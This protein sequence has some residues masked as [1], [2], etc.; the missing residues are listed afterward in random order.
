[1]IPLVANANAALSLAPEPMEFWA[2]L[3]NSDFQRHREGVLY[4][5]DEV[6][7]IQHDKFLEEDYGLMQQIGC[8]GIRDAARWYVTHPHPDIFNWMWMDRMVAAAGK[9][10][11]KMYIDLWHYGTP[12]WLDLMSP[13]APHHFAHFAREIALRYPSIQHYC[14]C[15][16]P[17][18]LVELGG[19]QGK[20][21]PFLC[22][23]DPTPVRQQI[24]KMIIEASKAVLK[25]RPD[26]MLIIPEPWHST[27][28]V[29]E[30]YQAAVIDTV[31]G[32]RDPHLGGSDDLIG[33]IGLNHYRDSTLPPFHKCIL[34]ARKRWPHKALWLTETSGPPTGWD[35]AEWFWWM[36]AET[37]LANMAG[38]GVSAFTWA[39][40][41]SM[42]DWDDERI[43]LH[44]GM[45]RI[46]EHGERIPNGHALDAVT[47]AREYGYIR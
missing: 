25:V 46:G 8:V 3:E 12:D 36:M 39:P 21:R 38:A 16:E 24:S 40:I 31:L 6:A 10:G 19:R 45:W 43:Q 13:D 5:Q 18:L 41:I 20:W 22:S 23:D 32:L 33:I 47:L 26:A 9:Y 42:F 29:S 2:F 34:N 27:L 11:L 7:L 28:H 37:R 17:S 4:R 15:N 44:N 1:M 14:I 35:Q 30:D